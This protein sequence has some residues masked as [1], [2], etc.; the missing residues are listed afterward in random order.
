MIIVV[1]LFQPGSVHAFT[2]GRIARDVQ[3]SFL[4]TWREAERCSI[5]KNA[6]IE[7][8]QAYV[9]NQ[10]NLIVMLNNVELTKRKAKEI[11]PLTDAAHGNV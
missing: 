5:S 3:G 11:R 6:L 9:N 10:F 7:M 8:V 1:T 4:P 2:L